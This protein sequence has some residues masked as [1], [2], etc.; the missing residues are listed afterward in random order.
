[1]IVRAALVLLVLML[2]WTGPVAAH[3]VPVSSVDLEYRPDRIDGAASVHISDIAILLELD[4]TSVQLS[5]L[6]SANGQMLAAIGTAL[7][8]RLL[9][10]DGA[11]P[12]LRW[13]GMDDVADDAG[14]IRLNFTIDAPP[15]PALTVRIHL[16]SHDA[17]HLTFVNIR[18]DGEVRQQW[19]FGSGTRPQTYYQGTAAGVLSVL[20][21]FIPSG[22]HHIIIGPDHILFLIGLLL[23][24][25]SWRRLVLI[26]T[27]FTIGHSVTLSLAALNMLVVPAAIIEPAIALSI[28]VVGADNLLR[29]QGR[30]LR[31]FLAGIF[32]LIHGFGFA[33]V[34]R[35]FGLPDA[36]LAWALFG[37]NLG[38][39]LGQIAIVLIAASILAFIRRRSETAAKRIV[40]AGSLAVMAAGA[41][42]FVDRVFFSGVG[43]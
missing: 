11:L 4:E 17:D 32:G 30:D 8:P 43:G 42:W 1:M 39:E 22:V 40:I 35:D 9:L 29:G 13:T 37:F 2:V 20:Q 6:P 41:Y 38:V 31:P 33:Y 16:F 18:E 26:V 19:I 3:P 27:C 12:P 14:A 23:L 7:A 21:T 36:N 34:L 28:V 25:G 15:P 10:G 24:G 5:G